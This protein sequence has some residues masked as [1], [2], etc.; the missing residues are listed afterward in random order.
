MLRLTAPRGL[1]L[2]CL[3]L[4]ILT[5]PLGNWVVMNVGTVCTKGGPC[6]IPVWQGLMAP[7]GVLL[8]GLALVL[9]DG[10]QNMLGKAWTLIAIAIGAVLSGWLSEPAVIL[11][12]TCAFLFSE[13]ADFAVYT[14]LRER[15]LGAAIIASGFV[16][17]IVDSVIF[18][19]ISFGSLEYVWG[20]VLGKFWM[21]LL[22]GGLIMLWH[23]RSARRQAA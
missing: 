20:Q 17:S 23:A 14:P 1:G 19:S 9:R 3:V 7:S 5:I 10:V 22:G 11:G 4:F 15:H 6:L 2:L 21:S 13:L 16:G 18:L 8:A 12:S